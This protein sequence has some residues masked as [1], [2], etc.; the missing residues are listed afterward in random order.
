MRRLRVA[1]LL[2]VLLLW[3][4]LTYAHT[5]GQ[6]YIFLRIYDDAIEA[7]LEITAADLNE[8]LRLNLNAS[9]EISAE[10]VRPYLDDIL[11]YV[12]P[13]LH[14][15]TSEGPLPLTFDSFDV[16]HIEIANY[17]VL[18]Y[19]VEGLASIPEAIDME[20]TVLFEEDA[21][22]RNLVVVE[23]NWKTSTFNNE[24]N[25][26]LV[27]SPADARQS[28]DLSS[29]SFLNGFIGVTKLGT[30]H[31]WIGIDHIL[32]LLALVLPAVLRRKDGKWVPVDDFKTALINIIA[33]VTFFTI[34]HSITLSLAALGVVQLP[35]WLVES[36]IAASIV[37][38]ALLNLYARLEIRERTI[39]FVFGLFHGLGFASVLSHLGLGDQNFIYSL[40]GFNLGVE[41]GQVVIIAAIFPLLYLLRGTRIYPNVLRLGSVG[42]IA[43]AT[44]WFV[45]RAFSV[46][47]IAPIK[48][49]LRAGYHVVMGLL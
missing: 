42:L 18:N 1:S 14:L 31:I 28:L 12:N 48:Q 33:I 36:V 15:A 29:A 13:R 11:A 10:D 27:L 45:E 3:P 8:V 35:S 49:T 22:H 7:R 39:A 4:A 25:V 6:S 19:T 44:F 2:F 21:D 46:P 23:H 24:R 34:A 5:T 9:G 32:F 47:L 41:I 20:Y 16:R 43:I 26:S 37:V 40:L 30:W 38:A 17:V